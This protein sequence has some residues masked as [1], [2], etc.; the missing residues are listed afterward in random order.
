LHN[1]GNPLPLRANAGKPLGQAV[2]Q[3]QVVFFLVI[4]RDGSKRGGH[5]GKEHMLSLTKKGIDPIQMLNNFF[6]P[7]KQSSSRVAAADPGR[8]VFHAKVLIIRHIEHAAPVLVH[9]FEK[10]ESL[11]TGT[12]GRILSRAILN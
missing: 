3:A 6:S 10:G 8:G 5:A 1:L 2:A 9:Q 7:A 4:F 11:F 12:E